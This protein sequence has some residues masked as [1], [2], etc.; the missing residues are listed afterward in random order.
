MGLFLSKVPIKSPLIIERGL[1]PLVTSAAIH[2][3]CKFA[4]FDRKEHHILYG[5]IN[6]F[7]Y[8]F[9]QKNIKSKQFFY[10]ILCKSQRYVIPQNLPV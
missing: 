5:L 7:K 3:A 4:N 1:M 10:A 8:H 2:K 6:F 9:L